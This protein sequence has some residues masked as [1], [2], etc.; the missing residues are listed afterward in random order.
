MPTG[1]VRCV[2]AI[3]NDPLFAHPSNVRRND[4]YHSEMFNFGRPRT[5]GDWIV[6][7]LG[8]FIALFLIWWMIRVFV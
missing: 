3:S 7:I 2:V 8:A 1:L 4:C 6:H 5:A